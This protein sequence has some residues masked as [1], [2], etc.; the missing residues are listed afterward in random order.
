MSINYKDK[1]L[2]YKQKYFQLKKIHDV[3]YQ[4]YFSDVKQFC[5]DTKEEYKRCEPFRLNSIKW[6]FGNKF[7]FNSGIGV[8][9]SKLVYP[10]NPI[11]QEF[12]NFVKQDGTFVYIEGFYNNFNE[13]KKEGSGV[14]VSEPNIPNIFTNPSEIPISTISRTHAERK[15]GFNPTKGSGK[16]NLHQFALNMK[17]SGIK[18]FYLAADGGESL[19][20]LYESYGFI[21]YIK[22]GDESNQYYDMIALVDDVISKTR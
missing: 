18:Y 10:T 6:T 22:D 2:K 16:V 14:F 20:S 5:N 15:R 9:E 7:M 21:K 19:V 4:D 12:N 13:Y 17:F 11:V 1:Y 8:N 3:N